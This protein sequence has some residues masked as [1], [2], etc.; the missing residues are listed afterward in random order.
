MKGPE[1]CSPLTTQVCTGFPRTSGVPGQP[2]ATARREQQNA[3]GAQEVGWGS[4]AQMRGEEGEPQGSP[5]SWLHSGLASLFPAG[6]GC[7]PRTPMGWRPA[8]AQQASPRF[9]LLPP[10][11]VPRSL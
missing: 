3:T 5:D 2:S 9:L 4:Q 7:S 10:T 8:P 6:P 1:P 11:R